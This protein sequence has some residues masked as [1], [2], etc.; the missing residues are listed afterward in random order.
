MGVAYKKN[1]EDPRESPALRL[2]ELIEDRGAT[3]DFH[4]PYIAVIPP[5]REHSALAGR[6]SIALSPGSDRRL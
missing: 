4:D 3:T 6:R 5:T 2:I 1:I